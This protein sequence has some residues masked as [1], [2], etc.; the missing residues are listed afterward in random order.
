MSRGHGALQDYLMKMILHSPDPMTFAEIM[1]IAFPEGSYE[2][3]M[4]K[5]IGGSN[6]G[7]IRSLRRALRRLCD[8]SSIMMIGEGGRSDPHRYW[9][10]P[11]LLALFGDKTWYDEVRKRIDADPALT[12]AANASAGRFMGRLTEVRDED[13]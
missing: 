12:A 5:T 1:A 2:S 13:E 11:M 8:D 9:V 7:A 4:A 10:N 3:D 6:V